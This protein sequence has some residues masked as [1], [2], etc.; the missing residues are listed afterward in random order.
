MA[1]GQVRGLTAYPAVAHL[2]EAMISGVLA[3]LWRRSP[4]LLQRPLAGRRFPHRKCEHS[5]CHRGHEQESSADTECERCKRWSGAYSSE[6]PSD[7]EYRCPTN[8]TAIE[9]SAMVDRKSVGK[10]R[11][12]GASGSPLCYRKHCDAGD[13]CQEQAGVKGAA[14]IEEAENFAWLGEPRNCE[15]CAK[16][17]ARNERTQFEFHRAPP[18]TWRMTKAVA[19]PDATNVI[20]AAMLR[21]DRRLTPHKP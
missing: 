13:K 1:T 18:N 17:Q 8:G 6:R 5:C 16:E 7:T 10:E 4:A 20:V 11:A 21:V 2:R 12:A 14:H 9:L 3:T 15:T 19:I